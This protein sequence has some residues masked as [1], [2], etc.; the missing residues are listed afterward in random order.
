[1]YN[2]INRYN[3]HNILQFVLIG[4]VAGRW[5]MIIS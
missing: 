4:M 3:I 1:M 2:S 5:D